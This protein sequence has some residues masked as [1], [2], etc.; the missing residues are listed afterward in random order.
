MPTITASS[1]DGYQ[2]SS[3]NSSWDA[4]HDH[5]GAS[6]PVTNL[7]YSALHAIRYEYVSARGGIKYYLTRSFFDFDTSSV[8][9]APTE[10]TFKLKAHTQNTCTPCIV[11]KSGHD[12]SAAATDD[13][14]STWITDQSVTL[15]G[16]GASDI[17]AYSASTAMGSVDAFTDF[18]LNEDARDDM[19]SL[20]TFKICVLHNNDYNDTAPTSGLLRTGLYWAN[21]GTESHRPYIDYTAA[22]EEGEAPVSNATFFGANF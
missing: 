7:T 15:S 14:F 16:W 8:G 12:P 17:T 10:A 11:A 22:E 5:V 21:N 1:N 13:W 18:T 19:A 6:N 20:S 3:L 9:S 2:S 4:V